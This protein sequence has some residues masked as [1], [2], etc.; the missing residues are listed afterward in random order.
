MEAGNHWRCFG[1]FG[2][3]GSFGDLSFYF[4]GFGF[5]FDFRF[6]TVWP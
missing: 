3:F 2:G 1:H 5:D 6:V 4:G